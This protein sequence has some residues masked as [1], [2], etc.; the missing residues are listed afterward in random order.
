MNTE[1]LPK[2]TKKGPVEL[3]LTAM[4]DVFSMIVIF[5]ILGGVFG[6]TDIV[7][8]GDMKIPKSQSKE[9]IEAGPRVAILKDQVLFS[10]TAAPI[11]LEDFRAS[12]R[13]KTIARLR[14][15][16]EEY[17]KR[18][19]ESKATVFPLNLLA[20]QNTPYQD[21]YDVVAAFRSMGFNSILFVAQGE[22]VKK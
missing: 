18:Q 19:K 11:P 5:L 2:K 21:V 3:Q 7:I 9:G 8:P 22:G 13:D 15:E 12:V 16:F 1:F 4:I 17:S 10:M 6:A 20:D 14:P